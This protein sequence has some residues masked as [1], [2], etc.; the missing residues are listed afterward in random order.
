[1]RIWGVRDYSSGSG[2]TAKDE[3]NQ[4]PMF[5]ACYYRNTATA[6]HCYENGLQPSKALKKKA[7]AV[8]LEIGVML[9]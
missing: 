7:V 8:Q 2:V 4:F 3:H 5:F 9:Y 1:M 6:L